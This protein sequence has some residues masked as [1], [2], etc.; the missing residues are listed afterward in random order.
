MIYTIQD[1]ETDD[2]TITEKDINML[3]DVLEK[4]M[5]ELFVRLD[6]IAVKLGKEVKTIKDLTRTPTKFTEDRR[7]LQKH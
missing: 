2:D 5:E 6:T 7:M 3:R 1:L 4:Q